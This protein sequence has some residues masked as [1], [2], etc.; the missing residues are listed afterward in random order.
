[1]EENSY[2][3]RVKISAIWKSLN[4]AWLCNQNSFP[5]C[6]L[7]TTMSPTLQSHALL[8]HAAQGCLGAQILG[9]GM[10]WGGE[11]MK[12]YFWYMSMDSSL[13]L[14]HALIV[15]E[16]GLQIHATWTAGDRISCK[17]RTRKMHISR[18]GPPCRISKCQVFLCGRWRVSHWNSCEF[19]WG[20]F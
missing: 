4:Y 14:F 13:F 10:N 7:T 18:V 3:Q 11:Q 12:L 19:V 17:F 1:M 5:M 20:F 6:T 8:S 16:Q 15:Q 2:G 9:A